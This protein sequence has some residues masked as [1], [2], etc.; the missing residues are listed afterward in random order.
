MGSSEATI[1]G[2]CDDGM[3]RVSKFMEKRFDV[4]MRHQRWSVAICRREIAKQR[5]GRPLVLSVRKELAA[6]DVELRE[7]VEFS[8]AREHVEIK[9]PQRLARG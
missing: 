2:A 1:L 6:D 5:H 7:V 4:L 3:Q 8:L 9:H